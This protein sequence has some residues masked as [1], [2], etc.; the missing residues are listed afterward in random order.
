MWWVAMWWVARWSVG[1]LAE[2]GEHWV[3]GDP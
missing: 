2:L 1:D 3:D